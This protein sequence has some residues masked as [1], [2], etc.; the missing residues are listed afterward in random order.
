[1]QDRVVQ[2]YLPLSVNSLPRNLAGSM[3]NKEWWHFWSR[4]KWK[5]RGAWGGM[6]SHGWMY[7]LCPFTWWTS[8]YLPS[9]HLGREIAALCLQMSEVPHVN[10][11]IAVAEFMAP[12][13]RPTSSASSSRVFIQVHPRSARF[14]PF[15]EEVIAIITIS[16][17]IGRGWTTS[18]TCSIKP[19]LT[20]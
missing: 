15:S 17:D 20:R 4:L 18:V 12:P 13:H 8:P 11:N 1:M 9:R 6:T 7:I 5:A 19:P 3:V 2:S 10:D 16:W 14:D